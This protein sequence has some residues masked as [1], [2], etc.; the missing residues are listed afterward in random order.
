MRLRPGVQLLN[1]YGSR[2]L[3]EWESS[4][5]RAI[6]VAQDQQAVGKDKIKANRQEDVEGGMRFFIPAFARND[7]HGILLKLNVPEGVGDKEVAVVEFK[8]KDRIFK[9]NAADEFP[10]KV[11]YANS[12][13][14]SAK[15]I[16]GSVARTVQGFAAGE[17]LMKAANAIASGDRA[18]ASRLLAEREA[19][20]HTAAVSLEE[21]LFIVD[22]VRLARLRIQADDAQANS[23]PLT[24]AM[25]METAASV[26]LH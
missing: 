20:L 26:H 4:R 12:D 9:K 14:E 1:V 13:A 19:L 18:T 10:L 6:E 22:A 11:R 16:D 23:D 2:R 25:I 8:Y 24:V 3:T 15:S 17:T 7:S 21:P 5:V